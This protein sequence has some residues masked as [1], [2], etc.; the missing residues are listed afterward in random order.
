MDGEDMFKPLTFALPKTNINMIQQLCRLLDSMIDPD[1]NID[2]DT[3]E[4]VFVFC[5]VWSLGSCLSLE[6]KKTFEDLLKKTSGRHLTPLSLFDSYYDFT[7]LV[8]NTRNW[9]GWEKIVGEYKPPTDGKFCKILVPT[10]DTKR[11]SFLLDLS[12]K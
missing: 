3:L 4:H 11:F 6:S 5:I 10:V 12:V 7:G 9:I 2:N 1:G 8:S